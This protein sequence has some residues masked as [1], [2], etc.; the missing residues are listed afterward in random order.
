M[1]SKKKTA[2]ELSDFQSAVALRKAQL[3]EQ[4]VQP[5]LSHIIASIKDTAADA[6][7]NPYSAP[8]RAV[9]Q[10]SFADALV[11]PQ[12]GL[13]NHASH[14]ELYELGTYDP[15][16]GKINSHKTPQLIIQGSSLQPQAVDYFKSEQY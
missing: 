16:S 5:V 7:M 9:A 10:R 2:K 8:N 6:F 11:N 15:Q 1:S 3:T 14:F 13:A 4:G 12:S